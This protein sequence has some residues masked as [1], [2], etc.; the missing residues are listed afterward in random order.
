MKPYPY[1]K[2]F[3]AQTLKKSKSR[4]STSEKSECGN[5]VFPFIYGDRIHDICT[6]IDGDE[7]WCSLTY[8]WT[9]QWEYCTNLSCPGVD[10]PKENM[11]VSPGNEVG[12]CC[13]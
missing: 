4:N 7:P 12:S 10:S 13:K 11:T 8:E 5:C 9:G 2:Y 1:P 3:K 6:T